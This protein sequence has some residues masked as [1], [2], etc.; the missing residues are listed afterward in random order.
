MSRLETE[1]IPYRNAN[2]VRNDYDGNDPYYS[3]HPDALSTGDEQGKGLC[4]GNVG[5]ATDIVQRNCMQNKN[6]YGTNHEYDSSTA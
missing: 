3:G 4:A 6:M 2:V 1:S 5:G